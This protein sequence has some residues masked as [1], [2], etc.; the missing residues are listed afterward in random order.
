M[1]AEIVLK[2][3][4]RIED[5]FIFCSGVENVILDLEAAETNEKYLDLLDY[6]GK[7]VG[8]FHKS[9]IDTNIIGNVFYKMFEWEFISEKKYN[10]LFKLFHTH[11]MCGLLMIARI[12]NDTTRN[13]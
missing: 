3:D 11:K 13:S 4:G 7:I 9:I 2:C 8:I 10:N 6:L 5:G 12:K 1:K